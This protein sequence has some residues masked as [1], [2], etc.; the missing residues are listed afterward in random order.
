[1][2]EKEE[3]KKRIG[4]KEVAKLAGVSITTVSRVLN[5]TR[6]NEISLKTQQKVWETAQSLCYVPNLAGKYLRSGLHFPYVG[7]LFSRGMARLSHEP[8]FWSIVDEINKVLSDNGLQRIH[9]D[10]RCLLRSE[11]DENIVLHNLARGVI[12]LDYIDD[13][14]LEILRRFNGPIISVFPTREL[15]DEFITI[16][17]DDGKGIVKAVRY[18]YDL[19][20]RKFVFVSGLSGEFEHPSFK[21]RRIACEKAIENLVIKEYKEVYVPNWSRITRDGLVHETEQKIVINNIGDSTA[22]CTAT[23]YIAAWLL[24][25]F[26][27]FGIDVPLNKSIVGFD[28]IS[29]AKL[30]NPPLT[31]VHIP[32]Q[33]IGRYAAEY[34]LQLIND[35]HAIKDKKILIDVKLIIRNSC[36]CII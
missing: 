34:C 32:T 19:G 21:R 36:K 15:D 11:N 3:K 9:L 28:D 33:K 20:H 13:E 22:I 1:M 26:N 24:R 17:T 14:L 12:T 23:D 6:V 30:L 4:I 35:K 7:I 16:D 8:F 29:L 2:A 31:T 25:A 18:L 27:N 5:N 10:S